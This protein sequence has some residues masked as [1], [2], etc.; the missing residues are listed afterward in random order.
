M[1]LAK[2]RSLSVSK[3]PA[4]DGRNFDLRQETRSDSAN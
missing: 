1:T 4:K 3:A 2:T